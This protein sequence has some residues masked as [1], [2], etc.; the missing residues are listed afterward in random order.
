MTDESKNKNKIE[1]EK[2]EK[3]YEKWVKKIQRQWKP[4]EWNEMRAKLEDLSLEEL[5]DLTTKVGIKFT[6]GNQN[7]TDKEEFI[8]VLDEAGRKELIRKYEKIIKFK[9]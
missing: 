2:R 7:I 8:L 5:R 6:I 1:R 9:K 4:E 3:E